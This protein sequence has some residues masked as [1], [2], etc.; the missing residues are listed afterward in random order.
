MEVS[1]EPG[2]TA[3]VPPPGDLDQ[4]LHEA[5]LRMLETHGEPLANGHGFVPLDIAV[6]PMEHSGTWRDCVSWPYKEFDGNYPL[7]AFLGEQGYL[8]AQE[9]RPGSE[10]PQKAFFPFLKTALSSALMRILA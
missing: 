2:E 8:L 1:P 7:I 5:N 6:T 3:P 4:K 10:H 9:P